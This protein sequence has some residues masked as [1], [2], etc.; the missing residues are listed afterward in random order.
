MERRERILAAAAEVFAERGYDGAGMREVATRAGISTPVLYDHFPAKAQLYS[1]LLQS[2]VDKLQ[3]AWG[4]LPEPKDAEELF[5]TTVDAIFGW[6]E[7]N[8]RGWRMIFAEAPVDPEVA[9]VHRRAQAGA[10][11]KL[12]E[13][14]AAV[15][16]STDLER[17][18]AN[19][20]FAETYKSA[21]NAIAG[22]WW[23]NRDLPRARVVALTTD[24]LWHG[25]RRLTALPEEAL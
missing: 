18:R 23:H 5:T 6:I 20:L 12:A 3:A 2:E 4:G 9:E 15:P 10:T 21:V 13:L 7:H 8:E 22:W 1:G 17:P 14:F 25:L 24:L 16:L 11:E 19:E